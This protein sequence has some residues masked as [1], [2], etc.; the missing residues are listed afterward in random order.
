MNEIIIPSFLF[1]GEK[2]LYKKYNKYIIE[3][4]NI[5]KL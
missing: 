3:Q 2:L 1:Y 4:Y 5:T